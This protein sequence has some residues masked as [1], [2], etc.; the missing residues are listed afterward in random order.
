M[1]RPGGCFLFCLPLLQQRNKHVIELFAPFCVELCHLQPIALVFDSDPVNVI[2]H[3]GG[4]AIK[5]PPIQRNSKLCF[6]VELGVLCTAL[7]FRDVDTVPGQ[8]ENLSDSGRAPN[9]KN[10]TR[11]Q[12]RVFTDFNRLLCFFDCP[13]GS[14]LI[15][16][17]VYRTPSKS[18]Y[19][20]FSGF[21][22]MA[23]RRPASPK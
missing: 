18:Q 2:V 13:Y 3:V 1:S 21:T 12:Y 14:F 17:L 22:W 6:D 11:F 10:H 15:R 19:A 8:T 20:G 9:S 5:S 4:L 7:P 23:R 16:S